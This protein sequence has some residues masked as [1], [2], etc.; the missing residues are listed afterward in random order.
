VTVRFPLRLKIGAFTVVLVAG[1]CA[2]VW[3][4]AVLRPLL[5]ERAERQEQY[6]QI[7]AM[8]GMS[9]AVNASVLTH[10]AMHPD[11][12]YVV[13]AKDGAPR[14][15]G[16]VAHAERLSPMAPD[17]AAAWASDPSRVLSALY[18]LDSGD[19]P[20]L[21]V[22]RVLLKGESGR[23]EIELGF[24]TRELDRALHARIRDSALVLAASLLLAI[25]GAFLLAQRIARPLHELASAMDRAGK[26]SM[27]AVSVTS[28]DEVGLLA[29]AF[30]DMVRGLKE[31]ERLK[32]TLAR[33]VSDDVAA[34]L[35]TERSDLEL[36]GELKEVT[37]LFLDI[38]GFT[39]LAERLSPREVVAM[40]NEYFEAV[41]EVVVKHHGSVNK[42]IGDAVMAI[43]GA[44]FPV[45]DSP[46]KAIHAAVEIEQAVAAVNEKRKAA[47]RATVAVG[48]GINT[49]SAV[50]G[51]V[52]SEKRMEYTVI[53]DE[54]NLAQRLESLAREGEILVSQST[55]DK[56]R[57]RVQARAREPVQV[58]GKTIPVWIYE[59][60]GL[61]A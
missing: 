12:V 40:L 49:G 25:I 46:M 27:D 45:D 28:R 34:R 30:N 20:G 39:A 9:G 17:L 38:R 23:E 48:I 2:A 24:S 11:L 8:L 61:A 36:K 21:V 5:F 7:Q 47:G 16:S 56:V 29:R 55:F 10:P 41:I 57:D 31:R 43:F 3:Y 50:A 19:W 4:L 44:P 37:V 22:K 6:H 26:G 1:A 35:L 51:N 60:I 14:L 18:P 59:I 15:E 54:V 32:S 33:Y 53:G 58:K 42:F 52:G 13:R